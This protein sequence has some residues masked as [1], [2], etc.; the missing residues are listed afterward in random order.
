MF[1]V[2]RLH[3]R[4]RLRWAWARTL[5][6]LM[7]WQNAVNSTTYASLVFLLVGGGLYGAGFV[8]E[9]F[10]PTVVYLLMATA[11]AVAIR[12]A[13]L[14]WN[15]LRAPSAIWRQDRRRI[16]TLEETLE[17]K[18]VLSFNPL[19]LRCEN[20]S[21]S[22]EITS[23]RGYFPFSPFRTGACPIR[24]SASLNASSGWSAPQ[25]ARGFDETPGWID[26]NRLSFAAG[27]THLKNQFLLMRRSH[28]I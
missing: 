28:A 5:E 11:T 7:P 3:L 17:P 22:T 1:D 6:T 2:A 23:G 20:I 10:E 27:I 16:R 18:L 8:K 21:S 14:T 25:L 24:R 15:Y 12:P 13:V 4:V 26:R 9:Q 19:R